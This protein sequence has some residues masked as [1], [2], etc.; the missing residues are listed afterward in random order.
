MERL[1]RLPEREAPSSGVA[2]LGWATVALLGLAFAIYWAYQLL[3]RASWT[4]F[5]FLF[6]DLGMALLSLLLAAQGAEHL[7]YATGGKRAGRLLRL[8]VLLALAPVMAALLPLIGYQA[9]G[10]PGALMSVLYTL[11]LAGLAW[12]VL[13]FSGPPRGGGGGRS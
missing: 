5:P 12:V 10:T 9:F 1:L 8:V 13:R 6:G 4:G 3:E 11:L 7:L 2:R